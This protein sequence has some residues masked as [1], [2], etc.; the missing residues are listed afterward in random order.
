M[1]ATGGGFELPT[2]YYSVSHSLGL[3]ALLTKNSKTASASIE[4]PETVN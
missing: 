2:N 4:N 1:N 3:A